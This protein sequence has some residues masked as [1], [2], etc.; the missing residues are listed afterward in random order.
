MQQITEANLAY[1][2]KRQCS[3][4]WRIFLTV[5]AED[6]SEQMN[7][8]DR[9]QFMLN[10][11]QR[12]AAKMP[13]PNVDSLVELEST[14]NNLW[15]QM[16]WG[17]VTLSEQDN[18]LAIKHHCAP[19]HEAFGVSAMQ[20]VPGLLQGVYSY[21]LKNLG[22]DNGLGFEQFHAPGSDDDEI[23]FRLARADILAQF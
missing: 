1:Y 15:L 19:L 10:L 5:L 23:Q 2:T 8:A 14:I 9:R 21:W 13:L 12:M 17:Y 20:W 7:A 16:D 11:G 4:Q 22:A 18:H 3:E 6:L